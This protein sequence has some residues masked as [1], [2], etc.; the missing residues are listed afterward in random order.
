MGL[1]VDENL[2]QV[3]VIGACGKM[4][5]GIAFLVLQ[6]MALLACTHEPSAYQ[7]RLI[8]T[9][10]SGFFDLKV[11]L[12][13][14]LLKFAEKNI[15]RLRPLFADDPSK[16]NNRDIIQ[17]FLDRALMITNCSTGLA[18]VA[19][20]TLIFEAAFEDVPIK[21]SILK[22]LHEIAKEAYVLTNTSSIPIGQLA[23][24]SG[25]GRNLIGYHFYN[26]PAVQKLL[27]IIPSK[28][29]SDELLD[30]AVQLGKRF[31][32][33]IVHSKDVAGF[34]GN[35]H[36]AAEIVYACQLVESLV[37]PCTIDDAVQMIDEVTRD[38][39]LRPMGIFQL[40]DYVG[41]PIIEQILH[42]MD[43]K[44]D[45]IESWRKSGL[46]GG[47]TYDGEPNNGIFHYTNGKKDAIWSLDLKEYI[48]LKPESLL[49]LSWK[50]IQ[51]D[52]K[53][54]AEIPPHFEKL[55]GDDSEKG[56]LAMQ[57]LIQSKEIVDELVAKKIAASQEDVGTVLKNGFF[58]LYNPEEVLK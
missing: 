29:T 45:L 51:K 50:K 26:P 37:P 21:T 22:S 52:P 31:G 56:K 28:E 24:Q 12:K 34:I 13:Q 47:Q 49:D 15:N 53:L 17:A 30:L 23:K 6:E 16:I 44:A 36:F 40:L 42:I 11:Y 54:L 46:V 38:Y 55:K 20:S 32:K 58:H 7:L 8:D 14:Q 27:E 35:G 10:A 9:N 25:L 48:P 18:S 33:T 3:A 1:M 2:N 39:L 4:G 5:R 57:F 41:L 43:L 19:G